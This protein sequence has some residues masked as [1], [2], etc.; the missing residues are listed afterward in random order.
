[1]IKLMFTL[2]LALL[3][4]RLWAQSEQLLHPTCVIHLQRSDDKE[5]NQ[6]LDVANQELRKRGF[7][8]TVSDF[9][10]P[11]GKYQFYFEVSKEVES[12]GFYPPCLATVFLK[13]TKKEKIGSDDK[14]LFRYTA[15]RAVP[16]TTPKSLSRCKLATHD[17]FGF[18]PTCLIQK[19]TIDGNE[20]N[21]D[22][23]LKP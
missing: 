8:P 20:E 18:Y 19:P 1:M 17:A 23:G 10:A 12:K 7:H 2:I 21:G 5:L 22:S 9:S 6:L 14:V 4:S 3:S 15:R 11:I 16:R 13:H